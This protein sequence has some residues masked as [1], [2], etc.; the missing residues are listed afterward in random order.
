MTMKLTHGTD[1]DTRPALLWRLALSFGRP[2]GLRWVQENYVRVVYRMEK[3]TGVRGPGFFKYNGLTERLGPTVYLG[4]RFKTYTFP[5]LSTSDPMRVGFRVSASYTFDPR[6]VKPEIATQLVQLDSDVFALIVEG[7]LLKSLR[8]LVADHTIETIRQGKVY[9]AIES[10]TAQEMGRNPGLAVLGL[11]VGN[12]EILEPLFP[13]AVEARFEEAAQRRFN[14]QAVQDFRASDVVKT[15]A[16][17]LVEKLG[18]Q[19]QQY[20]NGSDIMNAV[21]QLPEPPAAPTK[22]IDGQATVQSL[23]AGKSSS[24]ILPSTPSNNT[25]AVKGGPTT[26]SWVDENS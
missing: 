1:P 18:P 4:P 16:M 12:L 21:Q 19:T 24:V 22:T 15:L 2:F 17:E 10:Q 9:G 20:L 11:G 14:V 6:N 25:P 23:D 7:A 26:P 8:V 13:Q 3:Y 5:N